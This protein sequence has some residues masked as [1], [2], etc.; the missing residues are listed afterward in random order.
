LQFID[1]YS[2]LGVPK[3]AS[4]EEIDRA[5]RKLAR[6]YHPDVSK[7]KDAEERFKQVN[8]A[9][10][11]LKDPAKRQHYD[12]YG[13]AWREAQSRGTPPPGF[14]GFR[15]GRGAGPGAGAGAGQEGFDFEFAGDFSD[16]FRELFGLG[17]LGDLGG[18]G[19]ERR[20][21]GARTSRP[22]R[23]RVATAG[24]D[25]E[26]RITLSLEEAAR[27]G[28]REITL[29]DP[30]TGRARTLSVRIPAGVRSGQRIR[31][32]GQGDPG[33]GGGA[34]GDL[35]LQI[36]FVPHPEFWLDGADLHTVLPVPPWTAALGG[37]T[38]LRTLSGTLK[39]K[40]PPGTSSGRMIRIGGKGFP[41]GR[42]GAGDLY[43]EIQIVVPEQPSAEE[44]DLYE[45]LAR[46][47]RFAPPGQHGRRRPG[48][49]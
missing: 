2:V 22:V 42:G 31:L 40:V 1:Y 6:Q 48:S 16:F 41:D 15:F 9:Y 47:S 21:R 39:V 36:E 17:G 35:F 24:G 30:Q 34:A 14:E 25:Q 43:A 27:G 7:A 26:A 37:E 8:E 13:A 18:F 46:A 20:G 10:E 12:R 29:R 3:T 23:S 19:G 38:R 11:V 4:V 5:Y 32:A 49:T 44:R 28:P 33:L 45:R